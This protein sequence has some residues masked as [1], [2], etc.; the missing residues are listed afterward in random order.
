MIRP[1]PSF[2]RHS[3]SIVRRSWGRDAANGPAATPDA[4]QTV[5]CA[6]QERQDR[7]PVP[8]EPDGDS[9]VSRRRFDVLVP[10][11][12]PTTGLPQFPVGAY[13]DGPAVRTKD[14]VT[15]DGRTLVVMADVDKAGRGGFGHIYTISCEETV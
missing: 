7:D 1:S 9:V 15:W 6:V 2:F 5:V 8:S 4:G 10:A 11:L 3:V 14:L 13:P 12:H